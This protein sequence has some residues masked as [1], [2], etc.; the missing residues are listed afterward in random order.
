MDF[1]ILFV[2]GILLCGASIG[3]Y[4]FWGIE[5]ARKK[6][7]NNEKIAYGITPFDESVENTKD[8]E[9]IS[10]EVFSRFLY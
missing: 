10:Y 2:G 6:K 3:Y 8:E 4:V 7:E 1:M 5:A 9:I